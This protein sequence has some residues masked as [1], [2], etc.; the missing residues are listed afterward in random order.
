LAR[1]RDFTFIQDL[2]QLQAAGLARGCG[3]ENTII[4]EESG[5]RNPS[6]LRMPDEF[7][8][9]QL[10]D[11]IGDLALAGAAI[12]GRFVGHQTNHSLNNRLLHALFADPA[13]WVSTGEWSP[14]TE[15][16]ATFVTASEP[17][18]VAS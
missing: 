9:H 14:V 11:V 17:D 13:N 7:L 5:A 18:R 8:R 12:R 16:P 4:L 1:A 10:L 15:Q 6:G 2:A 3:I